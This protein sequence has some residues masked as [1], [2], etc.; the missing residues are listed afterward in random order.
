MK[1]SIIILFITAISSISGLAQTTISL[2]QAYDYRQTGE[3]N[4]PESVTYIKDI[5]NRLD[6]FVGIWEGIYKNRLYS[7]KFVKKT[8]FKFYDNYVDNPK[9]DRLIGWV[10]VKNNN[11]GQIIYSNAD[12][13]EKETQLWGIYFLKHSQTYLMS[14]TGNCYNEQGNVFIYINPATGKMQLGFAI[15]P[16]LQADDCPNGFDAIL[17]LVPNYVFMSKK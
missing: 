16:D 2:D 14:F 1:K 15:T 9:W 13:S 3:G 10:T 4:I 6:Q 8:A 12:K 5:D 11:T 17:P 7:F